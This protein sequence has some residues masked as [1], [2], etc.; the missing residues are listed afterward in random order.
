MTDCSEVQAGLRKPRGRCQGGGWSNKPLPLLFPLDVP[1]GPV[2]QL[3][4]Q[5]QGGLGGQWSGGGMEDTSTWK[6]Q[7]RLGLF[8]QLVLRR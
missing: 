2:T 8:L 7:S 1:T 5:S 6:D 3:A 4:G